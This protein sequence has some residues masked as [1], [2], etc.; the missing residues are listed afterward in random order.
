MISFEENC[1]CQQVIITQ[2]D[3]DAAVKPRISFFSVLKAVGKWKALVKKKHQ[4]V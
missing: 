3:L 2:S 1:A 4:V